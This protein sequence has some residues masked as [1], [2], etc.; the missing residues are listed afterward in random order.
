MSNLKDLISDAELEKKMET[1]LLEG[2]GWV[3]KLCTAY[4][5][6]IIIH[7][8]GP[9]T[10]SEIERVQDTQTLDILRVEL[11]GQMKDFTER[12]GEDCKLEKK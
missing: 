8:Q 1:I 9:Y 6:L 3:D 5:G 11:L 12:R 4:G 10:R 7:K 2:K